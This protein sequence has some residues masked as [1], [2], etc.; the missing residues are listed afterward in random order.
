[1]EKKFDINK[2]GHSIHAKWYANSLQEIEKVI[3]FFHGFGGHRDNN[4]FSRFSNSVLSKYKKVGLLTF[5]LPAHGS[6]AT[7]KLNLKDCDSYIETVLQYIQEETKAETIYAYGNSF[8]GY[9][10]LKYIHDHENPFRKIVLRSPAVCMYS[11]L[12]DNVFTEDDKKKIEK[13]KDVLIGFDRK[14]KINKSYLD[15]LKENDVQQWDYIPFAEDILVC[16]GQEDEIVNYPA[17]VDFCD[18]NIIELVSFEKVEH[19]FRNQSKLDECHNLFL[20]FL[21]L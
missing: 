9:L 11:V 12:M 1:M 7:G 20:K 5:D 13:G 16:H 6:D 15:D 21:Q 8:G 10:V 18:N 2:N 17:V 19:R 4:A 14:V 3:V